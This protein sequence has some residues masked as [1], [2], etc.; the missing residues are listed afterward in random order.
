MLF[1]KE[2]FHT[3][4]F[5]L[6]AGSLVVGAVASMAWVGGASGT[7][8]GPSQFERYVSLGS[9][10]GTEALSRDLNLQHPAGTS[11]VSLLAR[12]ERAGFGCLPD[13][14]HFT[15]YDCTWQRAVS[16]RRVAQIRAHVEANGV[17]VVSIAPQVGVFIR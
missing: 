11:L 5:A 14:G 8:N 3:A 17:Q 2:G 9:R 12:L 13:P 6:L 10:L 16:D 15:G 7:S 4:R 1:S